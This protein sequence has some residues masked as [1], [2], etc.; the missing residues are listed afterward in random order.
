MT[1]SDGNPVTAND[2][3]ATL[4]YGA[5]PEHAWDFTWHSQGVIKGWNE[6]VAPKVGQTA[7]APDS[8]GVRVGADDYELVIETEAPAP[9]LV[10]MLLYSTP[11]S[12]AA[13]ES[14]GPLDN[15]KPETAASSGPF[16]LTEWSPDQQLVY[17][18]NEQ[19]TGTLKVPVTKLISKLSAPDRYF[20]L[21]QNNEIDYMENP[22]PAD[23]EIMLGDPE[24]AK[25]VYS[26]VG[27]FPTY[28]IFFDVTKAPW[29]NKMVRQAWSHVI[30]RDAIKQQILGPNGTPAY[31]WLAP[32]FP[33]SNREGLQE[34]QKFDPELGKQLLSDAGYPNG[35]GFPK[36][37]LWL[38]DSTPIDK[39]VS[40]ACASMVKEHLNI[41]VEIVQKTS[42]EFMAALTAKPTEVLLGW[43][44]YGMDFFDP[45]NMLSVWLSDGRYS[46]VNEEY[47]AKVREAA[48]FL[49]PTEERIAKF[50]EAERILVED[51]P[52]VF[53]YH[54]TYVQFIKPW[55]VGD[56]LLPDENGIVAMHWPGY[57]TSTSVPQELYIRN[58]VPDR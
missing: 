28:H 5:D 22:G 56:F 17:S 23:Q 58:D 11:L 24:T 1:W 33:A 2:Y 36:Q 13:L 34:I 48:E 49:G 45:Y 14:S 47:D 39:A 18:K 55:V 6:V 53:V 21:Y 19:Y 27:D 9:Y 50:Q 7:A 16:I 35:D 57:G 15:T 40:S 38:R 43:V 31:S 44:R 4:Q 42:Q 20:T 3:V 54:G 37:E 30:D 51:V 32:G 10:A 41:D 25:E 8:I 29:D 46:W 52:A 12:K 26:G